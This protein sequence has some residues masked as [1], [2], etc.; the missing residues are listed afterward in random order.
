MVT[1]YFS[2]KGEGTYFSLLPALMLCVYW[3][4]KALVGAVSELWGC[5]LN[6]RAVELPQTKQ[7][8]DSL[9]SPRVGARNQ[10]ALAFQLKSGPQVNF[11]PF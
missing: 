1:S 11:K 6:P 2:Q 10:R 5:Y 4:N 8:D 3:A 7:V 9:T